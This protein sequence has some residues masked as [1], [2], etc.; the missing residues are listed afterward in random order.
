MCHFE[1]LIASQP[2][3]KAR[4]ANV[5][6]GKTF[7][8]PRPQNLGRR[9]ETKRK[10]PKLAAN[11]PCWRLVPGRQEEAAAA[12]PPPQQERRKQPYLPLLVAR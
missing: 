8:L 10:R 7:P 2:S 6:A 3:Q 11:Q 12:P 5:L 4:F 9:I 1:T